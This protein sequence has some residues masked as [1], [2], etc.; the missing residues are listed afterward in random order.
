MYAQ[1]ARRF[2][3]GVDWV[4]KEKSKTLDPDTN[5][6]RFDDPLKQQ[7]QTQK[8]I[9][10]T[11]IYIRKAWSIMAKEICLQILPAWEEQ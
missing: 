10:N 8:H 7:N 9:N 6:W 5:S 11:L 1:S 3:K 2:L 4:L